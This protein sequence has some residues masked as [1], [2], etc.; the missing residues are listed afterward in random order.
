MVVSL[1]EVVVLDMCSFVFVTIKF[2][3]NQSLDDTHQYR[4]R[5]RSDRERFDA[6]LFWGVEFYFLR[7][8]FQHQKIKDKIHRKALVLISHIVII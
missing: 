6:V 7:F 1:I 8:V 5:T 3:I 4:F 2:K